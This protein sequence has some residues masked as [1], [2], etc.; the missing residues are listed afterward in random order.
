MTPELRQA[1]LE[2]ELPSL[3][4]HH[5]GKY[6]LVCC[7]TVRVFDSKQDATQAGY[8]MCG[9]P[10]DFLIAKIEMPGPVGF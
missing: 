6:A 2:K 10:N 5:E 9:R 7:G 3:L 4:R 8:E 1:L